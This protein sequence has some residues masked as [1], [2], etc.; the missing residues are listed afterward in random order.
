MFSTVRG[1]LRAV[2]APSCQLYF[3]HIYRHT[4]ALLHLC[5]Y[6]CEC[7]YKQIERCVVSYTSNIPPNDIGNQLFRPICSSRSSMLDSWRFSEHTTFGE[8]A[9]QQHSTHWHTRTHTNTYTHT[10]TVTV[11]VGET[12]FRKSA[13]KREQYMRCRGAGCGTCTMHKRLAYLERQGTS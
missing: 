2:S 10:L 13:K 4:Q 11:T 5:M 3:R 6:A 1:A 7:R 8:L 12:G 9:A